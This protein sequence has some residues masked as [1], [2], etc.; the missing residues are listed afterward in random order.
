M[1]TILIVDDHPA[2]RM[3]MK[4][5]LEQ[6]LGVGNIP[7]ADNGQATVEAV[8]QYAPDLVVL[9]LDIP[10]INGLDVVPRLKVMQPEIRVLVVSGQDQSAFATRAMQAGAQ[11]FVSKTQDIRRS[12]VASRP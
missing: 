1:T 5:Q 11:G 7:E 6:I 8:R 12:S 4:A 3:V 9:D 2:L 10:K